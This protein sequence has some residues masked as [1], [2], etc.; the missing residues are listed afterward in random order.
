[1][2]LESLPTT[3]TVLGRDRFTVWALSVSPRESLLYP[4][5]FGICSGVA[6]DLAD[7]DLA[8]TGAKRLAWH[9]RLGSFWG[10]NDISWSKVEILPGSF[11]WELV[12]KVVAAYRS[13]YLRI[14]GVLGYGSAWAPDGNAPSTPAGREEWRGFVG[15][16]LKRFGMKILAYEVWNEPN[17]GFWKPKSNVRDYREL[18]KVTWEEMRKL[19]KEDEGPRVVA[20]VT[21]GYDPVFLDGLLADGFA[22]NLDVVSIHPYPEAHDE[23]PE[24]NALAKAC[25]SL[26]DLMRTHGVVEKERWITQIGWPTSPG[27]ATELQQANW[28]VRAYTIAFAAGISKVFWS[29]LHDRTRMPWEGNWDGHL[30]LMDSNYRPKPSASAYN[31]AQF[32]LTRTVCDGTTRQGA[33]AVTTFQVPKQS[34][35]YE[36]LLHV[37]WTPQ[38][39][40]ETTV[41][42]T[43]NYGGGM[44]AVDYLGAQ[45]LPLNAEELRGSRSG[46]WRSESLCTE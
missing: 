4:A 25:L 23:S 39:E 19:F 34:F 28:L 12:D 42:L 43:E 6:F 35:R 5:P 10:R 9:R 3:A 18:V 33:A 20:G 22:R 32:M 26:R 38:G 36:S 16:L 14:V 27:G 45:R 46:E 8:T 21:A 11:L 2:R 31:I 30:G 24:Q 37:A 13:E 44:L 29:D 15:Q 7:S 40:E 1:M 17:H 41:T